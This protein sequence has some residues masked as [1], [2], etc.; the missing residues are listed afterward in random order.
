MVSKIGVWWS[1]RAPVTNNMLLYSMLLCKKI[2][3]SPGG[4]KNVSP[5]IWG[6]GKQNI[7]LNTCRESNSFRST[8]VLPQCDLWKRHRLPSDSWLARESDHRHLCHCLYADR[9]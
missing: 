3:R 4:V 9:T 2:A 7:S 6:G 1:T 5:L 8:P